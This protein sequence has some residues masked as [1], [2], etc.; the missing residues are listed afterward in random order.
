[1]LIDQV[2]PQVVAETSTL[3]ERLIVEA[4][5][6]GMMEAETASLLAVVPAQLLDAGAFLDKLTT[7]WRYEFG[8]PFNIENSYY[9]GTHMWVPVGNLFIALHCARARL[10]D[11]QFNDYVARLSNPEKH[12]AILVEMI[13]A[14][15]VDATVPLEFEVAGL[16]TGNRT[17][18]WVVHPGHGP[19][20]LLDVKNR[21]A[22]FIKQAEQMAADPS[23][24]VPIH[25]PALLFRSIEEKF[26]PADPDV[27]LQGAWI[28][29]HIQQDEQLLGMSF[30]ALSADKVHFA[31]L[32]D[33]ESDAYVLARRPED[34]LLLLDL[35]RLQPSSRFT[36]R[37][38]A[39]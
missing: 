13:P 7:L 1:M 16:G 25:D 31:I 9:W 6:N 29:T 18:D 37:G 30:S 23:A 15:K 8:I 21:T 4:K 14:Q 5:E 36:F 17:V 11:T 22:D 32:G 3:R 35:F 26:L 12:Q 19:F 33:W 27:Q 28:C 24:Q 39:S 34:R 2:L 10:S 20:V 38:P